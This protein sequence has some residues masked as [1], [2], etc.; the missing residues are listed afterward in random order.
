MVLSSWAI[1]LELSS[2]RAWSQARWSLSSHI[3]TTSSARAKSK[4]NKHAHNT[5]HEIYVYDLNL[6][7]DCSLSF[8]I[9]CCEILSCYSFCASFSFLVLSGSD[10][11]RST[12]AINDLFSATMPSIWLKHHFRY[13]IVFMMSCINE[14]TLDMF[15]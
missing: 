13:F 1:F 5:Y 2:I 8:S 9:S 11:S 4:T 15:F 12:S 6:L 10:R 7:P 3:W 14:H